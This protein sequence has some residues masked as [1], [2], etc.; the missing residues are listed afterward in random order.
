VGSSRLSSAYSGGAAGDKTRIDYGTGHECMFVCFLLV[1]A[2]L[3]F[4]TASD[5]EA[6]ALEVFA[7]YVALVRRLQVF[8]EYVVLVRRVFAEYVELVRRVFAEYV[9]LVRRVFAEYVA[10]V[11]RVFAEYVVLVRRL[12]AN[13]HIQSMWH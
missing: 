13:T 1:L 12:S 9:A 4:F 8:A 6:L 3:N 10:L 5:S 11:R 2:R 7:E